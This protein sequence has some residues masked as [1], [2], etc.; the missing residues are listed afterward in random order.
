M[1]YLADDDTV[2]LN[3]QDCQDH[4]QSLEAVGV[5]M[6][7][8]D[9]FLNEKH[10]DLTDRAKAMRRRIIRDYLSWTMTEQEPEG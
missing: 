8:V 1:R 7:D 5:K 9:R 6:A 4:E 2:F 3:E 10:A